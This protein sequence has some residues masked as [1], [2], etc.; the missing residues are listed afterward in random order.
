MIIPE[1]CVCDFCHKENP[2]H[3]NLLTPIITDCEW[4]E[5][6]SQEPHV[7][8]EKCDI[9]NDCLLKLTNAK[10]GFR[11]VDLRIE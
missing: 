1:K 6:R 10:C 2:E 5:G 8:L 11:K 9:C 3:K 4:T 7:V